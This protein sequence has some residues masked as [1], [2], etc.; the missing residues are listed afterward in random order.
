MLELA[1]YTVNHVLYRLNFYTF[2]S[3]VGPYAHEV[4]FLNTPLNLSKHLKILLR[5]VLLLI[6]RPFFLR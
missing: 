1:M 4:K 2:L 6:Y 5:L 3:L